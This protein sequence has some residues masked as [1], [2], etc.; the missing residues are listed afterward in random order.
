MKKALFISCFGFYQARIKPIRD[1]VIKNGYEVTV[2]VADFNHIK[3][4]KI[5]KKYIECT[6]IQVP[7]YKKN[8]SLTRIYSHLVFGKEVNKQI[9][10]IKPDFI[11]ILVP[12]N[13][14]ARYCTKYKINH[15]EI[16][17][18]LDIID[19]WPESMPITY[20]SSIPFIKLWK[21]WRNDCIAVADH[22]FSECDLYQ[23][24]LSN[25]IDPNKV[26]TLHLFRERTKEESVIVDTIAKKF[27]SENK[28][29]RFAYLGSMNNIID[30]NGICNVLGKFIDQGY[31]TEL[32]A[33]GNGESFGE[34]KKRVEETGCVAHFYGA[35]FDECK[36]AELLAPC[37]FGLNMM[38]SSVKVG[39]TI[40][41]IHYLSLGLPIINNIK[42][43]TWSIVEKMGVGFNIDVQQFDDSV[44]TGRINKYTVLRCFEFLFSYETFRNNVEK[45]LN[46]QL[47]KEKR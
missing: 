24:E 35:I 6:Y 38:K 37:D 19:L 28:I 34:F 23:K 16:I 10:Q 39:L 44:L 11:Y 13:N 31:Y 26:S 45:I 8:L 42:G 9:K 47:G 2:L 36:I 12:P 14:T 29:V 30:I 41:S 15:Q 25:I 4:Q 5:E 7:S 20:Q 18:I 33:I 43:D 21:K 46:I 22:I 27:K 1:I 40:K 32:H 3:K 17:L